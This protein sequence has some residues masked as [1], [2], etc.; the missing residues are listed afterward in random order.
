MARITVCSG[1][2]LAKLGFLV[3]DNRYIYNALYEL[4]ITANQIET[5]IDRIPV[6]IK[7]VVEKENILFCLSTTDTNQP[8]AYH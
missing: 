4:T 3:F 1:F 5:H 8:L 6:I 7:L 2:S